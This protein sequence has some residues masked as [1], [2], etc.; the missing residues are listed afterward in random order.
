MSQDRQHTTGARL[1]I[2]DDSDVTRETLKSLL[3]GIDGVDEVLEASNGP[4]AIEIAARERPTS[5]LMDLR[6][7]GMN[8]F[9][10][11]RLLLEACPEASV[12]ALS[13]SLDP[14][15]VRRALEAGASGYTVKSADPVELRLAVTAGM[16]G[17][18]VLASQ[19]VYPVISHYV[20]LLESTRRRDRAVIESLAAAVEAKD[21]VTSRHLRRVSEQA[22]ALASRMG[23]DFATSEE[24]LFGCLL[25]DVGKI[26]V[27]EKIL[28]K[29]GPLDDSEWEVMRL[30][31]E[32]GAR[33]VAPLGLSSATLDVVLRHHERWDG[34]GYPDGLRGR[35][36]PFAARIFSVCDALD[37]MTSTRPYRAGMALEDALE[38]IRMESGRQFDPAVVEVLLASAE[39][40]AIPLAGAEDGGDGRLTTRGAGSALWSPPPV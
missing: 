32:I 38:A 29:P 40:G 16:R 7:P 4:D 19:V 25:H 30:H 23:S 36:I 18:G 33:V 22:V 28:G 13:A 35:D 8:G 39:S 10:A 3:E 20:E 37:A 6:M 21:A 26:G 11:T 1:L 34:G 14:A 31:P 9:E 15:D 17:R 27:P 5:V 24:F 12:I 2:V